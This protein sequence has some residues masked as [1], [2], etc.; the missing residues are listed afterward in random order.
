[1]T[2]ED[3]DDDDHDHV[4]LWANDNH[5]QIFTISCH[6][7]ERS[8]ISIL[9]RRSHISFLSMWRAHEKLTRHSFSTFVDPSFTSFVGPSSTGF[10]GPSYTDFDGPYSTD[11]AWYFM[12][13]FVGLFYSDFLAPSS[14]HRSLMDYTGPPTFTQYTPTF[15][16][17][18]SSSQSHWFG[19]T[20]TV[21]CDEISFYEIFYTDAFGRLVQ[22]KCYI[23][24]TC[25][26]F[27]HTPVI[28][29]SIITSSRG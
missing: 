1:M 13:A 26:T 20:I 2:M 4:G 6:Q 24:E 21:S 8:H 29:I 28:L 10:A 5:T 3:N 7:N 23:T 22:W 25:A 12:S 27:S 9:S 14:S 17:S 16:I 15:H 19:Y 18:E 11:V